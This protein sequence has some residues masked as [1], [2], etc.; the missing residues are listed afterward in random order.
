MEFYA[1]QDDRG[2]VV[3]I[4]DE[5]GDFVAVRDED[6]DLV[7]LDGWV[8]DELPKPH[9]LPA[10]DLEKSPGWARRLGGKFLGGAANAA[11]HLALGVLGGYLGIEIPKK[12]A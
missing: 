2:V 5:D 1:I 6:G 9:V 12:D 8:L 7:T 10:R 11:G 3:A 4:V